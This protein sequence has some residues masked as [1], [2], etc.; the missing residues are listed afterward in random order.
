M[1]KLA[2][3]GSAA[4]AALL[5]AACSTGGEQAASQAP[6][7]S[8]VAAAQQIAASVGAPHPGR[9]VYERAC[10]MCHDK[11]AETR[12]PSLAALQ[13]LNA[14]HI[15]FA[16]TEGVMQAQGRALGP[17]DFSQLVNYLAKPADDAHGWIEANMC[18]ADRR[19]VNLSSPAASA[20]YGVDLEST[21]RVTA[22]QAGLTSSDLGKLELEWALAFPETG[23][24]RAQPVVVGTTMFISVGD[25]SRVY[26]LDTSTGCV[27]WT[28]L[29][30]TP[31]RTALTYGEIGPG[32]RKVLMVGDATRRL[33]QLDALTGEQI[34]EQDVRLFDRSRPSAAPLIHKD[35]IYMALSNREASQ[36][37]ND[38]FECCRTHGGVIAMDALTGER[39]WVYHTME[40]A[41]LQGV[42]A[43]GVPRWG[44]SGAPIWA[45][46]TIDVKRNALIVT[47]GENFSLPATV[48]S[49]A[50]ISI[51]LDTGKQNWVFQGTPNDAWNSSCGTDRSGANCPPEAES[52]REDF[53]FGG[54]AV[55]AKRSDG[56]DILL[57]G[58]KSGHVWAVDPDSGKLLWSERFGRGTTLGGN[59][60]GVAVDD[61][62]VFVPINDSIR[63]NRIASHEPGM[64]A[65]D[66]TT[67][68]VLW[69]YRAT[70]ACDNG[71][72]ARLPNCATWHGLSSPPLVI[73]TSVVASSVDGWIFIFDA[74][75]GRIDWRF[76][77][78]RDFETVNGVKGNGGQIDNGAFVAANG[79][80]F[81]QSGYGGTPGNVL[82]KFTPR[83]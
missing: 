1:R 2:A 56:R 67:G 35:R 70:P 44:P 66:I 37:A 48:T 12:A 32:K 49:D 38:S 55:L 41:I 19:A 72:E 57:A 33:I 34:W 75:T 31:L 43:I 42:N 68:K 76:D 5:L 71:R 53:D 30:E 59:H 73:D 14:E 28:Y 16:L 15:R 25:T 8:P 24:M 50:I 62:R 40:G 22:Q 11:P 63:P 54:A 20:M 9:A 65:L 46:P 3:Y 13:V 6:A 4:F 83:R 7:A 82:L 51:D 26:A 78:A 36:A 79:S 58:Q 39:I 21:R 23:T 45:N 77:T 61:T 64:N 80:L 29:S 27:K 81:V 18:A 52:I 47:T 60:M 10:A 74:A 17:D 69:R